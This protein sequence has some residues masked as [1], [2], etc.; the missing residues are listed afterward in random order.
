MKKHLSLLLVVSFYIA[1]FSQTPKKI[2]SADIHENIKKLNVLATAFYVA[3][4]PDDENTRMIS[5]LANQYKAN[6]YY[7]SMTRGD[8]GQNLIGPEIEDLLGVIRTNELLRARGVDG[9]NQL[10]TRANDFGYSKNP[11]E[12]MKIWNRD[13]VLSDIIWQIRSYK[14]DII[15]NRFNNDPNSDTHGHH[16]TS[17][18]LSTE[19]FDLSNRKD[20]YPDQLKYVDPWQA[21]R[22][23]FNTFWWFYGSE[24]AFNK[25]DKSKMVSVDAGV[26]YPWL[27]K[28]NGE[29]A[30]ESRSM[31]RCQGM[32]APGIRGGSEE[33]LDLLKG[34]AI[35]QHENP[36]AGIDI[37]WNR[38]KGGA[39][40]IPLINEIEKK[41]QYENPA[42]SISKLNK[43]YQMIQALPETYWKKIKT[44]EIKTII[45]QCSGLYIEAV[46]S[47][48][49]V[50][51]GEAN[52]FTAELINR[53]KAKVIVKS[54]KFLPMVDSDTTGSVI[55]TTN[56][57][58]KFIR[59]TIMPKDL[60]NTGHYWLS[61]VREQGMYKVDDQKL[62]GLPLSPRSCKAVF[63][64]N[65]EG[66]NYTM[67]K[68]IVY[69]WVDPAKGE[70]YRPFEIT[71]P[72]FVNLDS[73]VYVYADESPKKITVLLKSGMAHLNGDVAL[74]LPD[75]WRSEPKS[76]PAQ[77]KIKG[78]EQGY[79]FLVYPP[80]QANEGTIRA[81]ITI[82]GKSYDKE[83][84]VIN[85]DHIPYQV[86]QRPGVARI[87]KLDIQKGPDKIAYINGAGDEVA[88]C[89]EQIGYQVTILSDKDIT[90]NVLSKYDAVVLGIRAYNTVDRLRNVQG[91]LME[92]VQ[93]GGNLIVQYNTNFRM[94]TQDI[95]PY[96]LR[97]GRERVSQE[98]AEM[99]MLLPDHAVLNIPNKITTKDFEHWIQE[100]GLYYP[101]EWDKKQYAAILSSNDAG[102]HAL[103]GGILVAKY[104]DGNFVYTGLSFFR[105]LP[106]GV[107]GAYRLFA[108]MLALKK[109]AK[110]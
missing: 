41:F 56:K 108:N 91:V 105:Q 16:T 47:N 73:K 86:V 67:E 30:G 24:E 82:D 100:R 10:F 83:L 98:D 94:V 106:S 20:I 104:G 60:V 93:R 85:Y 87:L 38:V 36:F 68:D 77:I 46:S 58:W 64:F 103:D 95:G 53:S 32:G 70:L 28:S 49:T 31:H 26:Y 4:H 55:L 6:V 61:Q 21:K 57:D 74:D 81:T 88:N 34:D 44:E 92:Y 3:A 96:T 63:E 109:N 107:P 90:A 72:A 102:E 15:I 18:I 80:A 71:V 2:T 33:Y 14:P 40:L 19:A 65:I 75:G 39:V 8:G 11:T 35:T 52:T 27:G 25:L 76:L 54:V 78:N 51:P 43:V 62:R 110:S 5:L 79:S 69:K 17:A 13:E 9:G 1:A 22:L 45:L 23:Y 101:S 84:V 48:H 66:T 59:N 7:L 29:I 37:T 97:I 50:A 42:A 12:T 99:R 89:L